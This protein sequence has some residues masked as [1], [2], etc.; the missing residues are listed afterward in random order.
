MLSDV[1]PLLMHGTQVQ[2]IQ[3]LDETGNVIT[4]EE[5]HAK[6][7]SKLNSLF[8][9]SFTCTPFLSFLIL[10]IQ[11][12]VHCGM[13]VWQISTVSTLIRISCVFH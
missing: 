3:Y 2:E 4:E 10:K 13:G 12:T 6:T 11:I 7:E 5:Y 1:D 9:L 8:F